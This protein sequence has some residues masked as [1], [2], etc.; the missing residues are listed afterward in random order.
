MLLRRVEDGQRRHERRL[1]LQ[2][3]LRFNSHCHC[4]LVVHKCSRVLLLLLLD[5]HLLLLLLLHVCLMLLLLLLR[6]CLLLLLC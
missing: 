2:R 5:T 3:P 6:A 4:L 1:H